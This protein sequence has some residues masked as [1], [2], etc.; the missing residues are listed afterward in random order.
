VLTR[1]DVHYVVTEY[2]IAYL[3]GKSIRERTMAL[4]EIA[5]PAFRDSLLERAK[6]LHYV[7]ADQRLPKS[8]LYPD[9]WRKD[10]A[11]SDGTVVHLR[12]I[13][14]RD[15]ALLQELYYSLSPENLALRFNSED[16]RFP[17]RRV[18]PET[19]VDYRNKMTVV[20]TVGQVGRERLLG[21]AS[22]HRNPQ[23][24]IAECAFTVH[25]QYRRRGIGTALLE[26]LT[27]IAKAGAEIVGFRVEVL[28]RNKA[29]LKLF[30]RSLE[31]AQSRKRIRTAVESNMYSLSYTFDED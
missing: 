11:L 10:I 4:I 14:P 23:T 1:S 2:G 18:H 13:R 8:S 7:Y 20:A 31:G 6:E 26:H 30:H 16:G 3:Y 17:H 19:I 25:E 15:E 24:N 27:T 9:H 29:M 21:V 5:H 28:A 12:P 22:Y